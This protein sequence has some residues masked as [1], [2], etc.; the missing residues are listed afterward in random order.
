MIAI[1]QKDLLL[2]WRTF[3]RYII[4]GIAVLVIAATAFVIWGTQASQG[5][6]PVASDTSYQLGVNA[7]AVPSA[8]LD[9]FQLSERFDVTEYPTQKAL[10]DAFRQKEIDFALDYGNELILFSG[11]RA[12]EITD[13]IYKEA[14][15]LTIGG[16]KYVVKLKGIPGKQQDMVGSFALWFAVI[17]LMMIGSGLCNILVWEERAKGNLEELVASPIS[18]AGIIIAKLASVLTSTA[19]LCIGVAFVVGIFF[20]IAATIVVMN[21]NSLLKATIEQMAST[22]QKV[23]PETPNAVEVAGELISWA[24][25]GGVGLTAATVFFGIL[26]LTTLLV[27][28]NFL[29]REQATLRFIIT[30]LVLAVYGVPWI[31]SHE[32]AGEVPGYW[33]FPVVNIYFTSAHQAFNE[34]TN[35]L[36]VWPLS[37]NFAFFLMVLLVGVY[38]VGKVEDWPAR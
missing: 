34:V 25:L 20:V 9:E 8:L 19:F 38:L 30:P 5:G 15:T 3:R 14:L 18:K 32:T 37:A 29:V 24:D 22:S 10:H 16:G 13:L 31:V 6:A 4:F 1:F 21:S 7:S 27:V 26:A 17:G 36:W 11:Q 28:I 33:A 12:S 35:W 2:I 23:S